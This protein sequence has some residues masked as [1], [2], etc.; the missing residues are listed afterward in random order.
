MNAK[1]NTAVWNDSMCEPANPTPYS[2]KDAQYLKLE[3]EATTMYVP[4][5]LET[6]RVET[7]HACNDTAS[8]H[9]GVFARKYRFA[10]TL[11]LQRS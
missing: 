8:N 5:Q 9:N 3:A 6:R 7:T 11:L 1:K 4:V 10:T 2:V